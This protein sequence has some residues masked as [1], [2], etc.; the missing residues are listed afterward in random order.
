MSAYTEKDFVDVVD[1]EGKPL[2]SVPK[3]WIGTDLLPDGAKKA[4]KSA[5]SD[6][7]SDSSESV[8]VP[9]GDPSDDWTVKQLDAYAA[10][11][12]IDLSGA[13]NK[14]EKLEAIVAS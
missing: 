4:G 11:H 5:K 10:D 3:A 13:S 6:K 8:T 12:G 14:T 9:E 1:A 2:G 7:P